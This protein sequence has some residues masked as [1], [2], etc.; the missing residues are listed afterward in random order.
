[1]GL[2]SEF[3][4]SMT[5]EIEN[6]LWDESSGSLVDFLWILLDRRL[7]ELVPPFF[8]GLASESTNGSWVLLI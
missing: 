1:M 7:D 4:K 3:T 8:S 5:N 2:V 6:A